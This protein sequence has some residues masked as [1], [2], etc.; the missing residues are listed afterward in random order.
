M[1]T[2]AAQKNDAGGLM[3]LIGKNSQQKPGESLEDDQN[4]QKGS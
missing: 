4:R 2:D 3:D 1:Q